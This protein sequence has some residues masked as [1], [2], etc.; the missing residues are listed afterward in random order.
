MTG[1][2]AQLNSGSAITSSLKKVDKSQ[3]THKN[4]A[5]RTTGTVPERS[6]S[7]TSSSS[8]GKSPMPNRKPDTLKTKKPPKKELDGNKWL[9]ENYDNTGNEV[10]EINAEVN[11]SILITRCNKTVVKVIGKATAI[12]IDNCTSLSILVD[13]LVASIDVIKS[14]KFAIQV[15][16]VVPTVL[17]DQVDGASIYL[18]SQS[19]GTEIFTSKCSSI[20]VVVPPDGSDESGGE[21]G[22]SKELM[23]PEQIRTVIV[24]GKAVSEVVEHAG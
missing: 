23:V 18:S 8:R 10:V 19:L 13:S 21:E 4:P 12:S 2:F 5:L 6:S 14:P 24:K 1:V 15:D 16:G 11:H 3:M 9:I 20:N 17:L 22:D 7:Q